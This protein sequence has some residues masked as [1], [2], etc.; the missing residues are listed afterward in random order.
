MVGDDDAVLAEAVAD[1]HAPS[2]FEAASNRLLRARLLELLTGL[3]ERERA[4]V[5]LRYG[6]VDGKTRTCAEVGQCVHLTRERVRQLEVVALDK[7]R[8]APGGTELA[9]FLS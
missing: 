9:E 2:P 8:H 5:S 6:L 1:E 4:I 3:P 7:L